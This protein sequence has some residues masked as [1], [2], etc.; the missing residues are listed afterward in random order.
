MP[1]ANQVYI[2]KLCET[3]HEAGRFQD[4]VRK[5]IEKTKEIEKDGK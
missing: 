5:R 2:C 1:Y 3:G 4:L